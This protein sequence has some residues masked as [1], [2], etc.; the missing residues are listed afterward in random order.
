MPSAPPAGCRP[1]TG[2]V[3]ADRQH[4]AGVR[5]PGS[6][7]VRQHLADHGR[8]PA[9][10]GSSTGGTVLPRTTCVP[11]GTGFSST[12]QDTGPRGPAGRAVPDRHDDQHHGAGSRGRRR[13]LHVGRCRAT[14]AAPTTCGSSMLPDGSRTCGPVPEVFAFQGCRAAP[15]GKDCIHRRTADHQRDPAAPPAGRLRPRPATRPV[16]R[17]QHHQHDPAARTYRPGVLPDEEL[18]R[19][20]A[21]RSVP[22]RV[23]AAGDDA[24]HGVDQ[25]RRSTANSSMWPTA[26]ASR[27][28]RTRTP[29]AERAGPIRMPQPA[30]PV[31]D[32]ADPAKPS[33]SS[34][35]GWS[36]ARQQ[37]TG[38][39]K[40]A[41]SSSE[42]FHIRLKRWRV[43]SGGER[44]GRLPRITDC[45]RVADE[46]GNRLTSRDVA[47]LHARGGVGPQPPSRRRRR[48]RTGPAPAGPARQAR[49]WGAGVRD[50]APPKGP[51]PPSP[52]NAWTRGRPC[53]SPLPG[54]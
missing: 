50:A 17:R 54:L 37:R 43:S 42:V 30:A 36:A 25:Q 22:D 52:P 11:P 20:A 53:Q 4:T 7:P 5:P 6:T 1:R 2:P 48:A 34:R 19:A 8:S 29:P 44:A 23:A 32:A 33:V 14:A 35:S 27:P 38:D 31:Q 10:A 12:A 46:P 18:C 49:N 51:G 26:D 41:R 13:T 45:R 39:R 15:A 28:A 40:H 9:S 16:H 21:S 3:E 47:D 24:Q